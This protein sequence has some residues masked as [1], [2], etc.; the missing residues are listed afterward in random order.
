MQVEE[1]KVNA[2]K[3]EGAKFY[4]EIKENYSKRIDELS[5]SSKR[6]MNLCAD[7]NNE[8]LYGTLNTIQEFVD[9]QKKYS[10]NFPNGYP[11]NL[12]LNLVKR[13]SQAWVQGVE[14]FDSAHADWMKNCKN[15]IKQLNENYIQYLKYFERYYEFLQKHAFKKEN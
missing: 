15:Q 4:D 8:C 13:N 14:N 9:M 3:K 1:K 11:Q 12:I 2:P 7:L 10:E 5:Y 6:S